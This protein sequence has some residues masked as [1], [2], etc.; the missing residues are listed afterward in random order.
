MSDR[1]TFLTQLH[2]LD[3]VRVLYRRRWLMA[4][5][6]GLALGVVILHDTLTTPLYQAQATVLIEP[7]TPQVV[8]FQ[9]VL[10]EG[11]MQDG[12][13]QTQLQMLRSRAL[14]LRTA[15]L[16]TQEKRDGF[17]RRS[18]ESGA[19]AVLAGL[20]I[21]PV[22]ATRMVSIRYKASSPT[23]AADV[24]NA[25]ARA[26]IQ[27]SLDNRFRASKEA[28]DWL[29]AQ[30]AEE[31]KRVETSE[32][33][34]QTYREQH[35]AV[36]L[37]A[38][39]NI[40][41]QKLADLNAAV[42]RA[43][44]DRIEKEAEY[45]EWLAIRKAGNLDAIPVVMSNPFIQQ[46]KGDLA[47][48]QREY[49][50]LSETLGDRHPTLVAKRT[51]IDTA[52]KRLSAEVDRVIAAQRN[53]FQ[54]SKAQ[55]D[56]LVSALEQQ[57]AEALAQNRRGIEYAALEREAESVRQVYL[58][59]LQRA[60]ETSV[61]EDLR[62]TNIRIVDP[63]RVPVQPVSPRPVFDGAVGTVAGLLFAVGLVFGLEYLD[64]RA[65]TPD[66][67]LMRVQVPVLGMVPELKAGRHAAALLQPD[68][69]PA[70]V[71]AVR[72]MR[73]NLLSTAHATDRRS[74][75]VTSA[76]QGE[77]KTF[78]ASSLAI[79]LAQS[80][81]RVLLIDADMRRPAVHRLFGLPLGHGLSSVLGG[82]ASLGDI[83]RPTAIPGL[84]VL[85]AGTPSADA[86]E[87]LGSPRFD[88]LFDVLEQH[89]D[90]LIIDSPPVLSV[91][92][93]NLVAR[94]STGVLF[95]VASGIT[96]SQAA[97]AAINELRSTGATVLGAVLTRADLQQHPFYF[98]PYTRG[99]YAVDVVAP[100]QECRESA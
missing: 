84:T 40:V 15:A 56:S 14:A 22:R 28:T 77:G 27:Q 16:L 86:P 24:T 80:H 61:A 33:A 47:R 42:T 37:A 1:L 23:V 41:V 73:T 90:W 85:T 34:L 43:K 93:A 32:K 87:L 53:A 94:R 100:A 96:R 25:H 3:Y 71:E 21:L 92:D 49:S 10:N 64:D 50:E 75:V 6:V 65:R 35:D 59:L 68:V 11:L 30:L 72:A 52:E 17:N 81:Q 7:D 76:R 66:D 46:L 91:T 44:T 12:Y 58:N 67:V 38:G 55:E 54:A 48:L 88:Q 9:D 57:K 79:A 4:A 18:A 13:F 60:K 83:L 45:R 89:F 69:P 74:I 97:C 31:R 19:D 39:Q 20:D 70:L 63:A 26:Y 2:P 98:A 29:D 99:D 5:V 62:I 82:E 36:S 95:V 78:V 51:E 8:N